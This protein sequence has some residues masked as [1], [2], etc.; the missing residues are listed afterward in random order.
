M[1]RWLILTLFAVISLSYA[2]S[3]TKNAYPS[4]ASVGEEIVQT[5]LKQ[6]K[7]LQLKENKKGAVAIISEPEYRTARKP[8]RVKKNKKNQS[9]QNKISKEKDT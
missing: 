4:L 5:A 3:P 8:S 2:Q 7:N 6:Q 1:K 9:C